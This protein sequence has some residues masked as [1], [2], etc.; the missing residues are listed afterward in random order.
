MLDGRYGSKG[1]MTARKCDFRYTS[2]S[3]L[4]S[5]MTACLKCAN[6][7]SDKPIL[8]EAKAPAS[9]ISN[10]GCSGLRSSYVEVV[11]STFEVEVDGTI[12]AVFEHSLSMSLATESPGKHSKMAR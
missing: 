7:G 1:D 4:N 2:G 8:V 10:E 12:G 9:D 3:G 6:F 11:P 5:D